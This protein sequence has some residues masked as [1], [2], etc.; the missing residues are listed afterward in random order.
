MEEIFSGIYMFYRMF[1]EDLLTK[2]EFSSTIPV[3]T[4]NLSVIDD[5]FFETD[6]LSE[7]SELEEGP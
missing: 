4:F 7:S 3:L 5:V 1:H 2:M 6:I